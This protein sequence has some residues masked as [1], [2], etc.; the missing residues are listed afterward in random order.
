MEALRRKRETYEVIFSGAK[1][2]IW[3]P[4]MAMVNSKG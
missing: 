3:L 2:D 1:E 4:L